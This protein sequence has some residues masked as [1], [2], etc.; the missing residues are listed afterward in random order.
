[1]SIQELGKHAV[2]VEHAEEHR[3]HADGILGEQFETLEQQ[4]TAYLIGMWAF[5]VQEVLFFG[6]IFTAY[7][8][9]RFEYVLEFTF[10][11]HELSV[12]IGTLNTF[13]LLF[14]SYTMARAVRAAMQNRHKKQVIYLFYTFLFASVFM[15]NKYF[16]Y[17]A[18]LEH[19]LFPSVNYDAHSIV[20]HAKER[21]ELRIVHEN[22]RE[23]YELGK[24]INGEF[25]PFKKVTPEEFEQR[26]KLFFG[27]YFVMT[28]LHGLHVL[29][30][31]IVIAIL[32]GRA[33]IDHLKN[34]PVADYMPVEMTGL[35]WHFVDIVWIFLFPLLYLIG[36]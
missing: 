16:E 9:Y 34:K 15:V 13:V 24:T 6:A 5:V 21:G 4:N 29:V 33:W 10:A 28:G 22:G 35:Y 31:M 27:F 26:T 8:I 3:R 17:G 23:M 30:G 18:K 7:A 36:R 12:P 32:I 25:R 14:S 2:A 20:E 19:H 1:M 11:H